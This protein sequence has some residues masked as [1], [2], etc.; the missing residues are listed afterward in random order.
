MKSAA[1]AVFVAVMVAAAPCQSWVDTTFHVLGSETTNKV[2]ALLIQRGFCPAEEI[3]AKLCTQKAVGFFPV[4]GGFIFVTL[5]VK[6]S[7]L[8][9]EIKEELTTVFDEH[10]SLKKITYK[11]YLTA[12][13]PRNSSFNRGGPI[14]DSLKLR[15]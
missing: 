7:A 8:I 4:H 5:D 11:A 9:Q 10:L 6:D 14:I 12:A 3:P 15:R 2:A 1:L 13:P